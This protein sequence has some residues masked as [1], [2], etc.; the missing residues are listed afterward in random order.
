MRCPLRALG[1]RRLA[2]PA[3]LAVVATMANAALLRAPGRLGLESDDPLLSTARYASGVIAWLAGAWLAARF[4][5]LLLRRAAAPNARSSRYPRLL[6]DLLHGIAFLIGLIGIYISVFDQA[7]TGL[8]ATSSVVIAVVG[9]A[10]RYVI[11]DVFSGVALNFD[12]PYRI[13]DWIE[14]S[15]GIIGKVVEI[16]WRTTRLVTRD[17][18]TVI[19]P[20]GII[21]TGRLVNYSD[22]GPSFRVVFRVSLDPGIPV[23]R[24]KQLLL[25][26]ALAATRSY[27]DL[28]PD[29]LVQEC[30]DSGI[31]Y[32]VRFWV[33][34]FEQEN[35]CRDAASTGILRALRHAG[36]APS[37][38]RREWI[39]ARSRA[40]PEFRQ[41]PAETLLDETMLFSAF[42]PSERAA[43]ASRLTQRFVKQGAT[44]VRQG[45]AA[46]S[47][48]FVSEGAFEVRFSE[49]GGRD[50][51]VNQLGAGDIF[52]EMSLLTGEPRSASVIALTDGLLYELGKEDLAPL[53]VERP[54]L[55][56]ALVELMMMRRRLSRERLD[57]WHRDSDAGHPSSH[58]GMLKRLK[59]FF[60]L[61]EGE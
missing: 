60:G 6:T 3:A 15:P 36:L 35:A 20:N 12:H 9:F 16:T 14:P 39:D 5:D 13:G 30:S 47:L 41:T 50:V 26:G 53:L 29:V 58:A 24:A 7:A 43:L 37:P 59:S 52:G 2:F 31:T 19:V 42:L 61:S 57:L 40:T 23:S 28:N 32:A 33:P 38:P 18:V 44:V 45:D 17:R 54:E 4:L 55:G 27:P 11:S 51:A 48:F 1:L 10:L 56:E 34:D 21:A 25:A 49:A 46:T 22:P 8:I